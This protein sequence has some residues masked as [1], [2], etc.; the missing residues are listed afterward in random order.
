MAINIL[1][2][3][4]ESIPLG[5]WVEFIDAFGERQPG[6]EHGTS[7]SDFLVFPGAI[8]ERSEML[9]LESREL[10]LFPVDKSSKAEA[11]LRQFLSHL[12]A[13]I[14]GITV[15]G[16][17]ISKAA[18]QLLVALCE[19]V[20]FHDCLFEGSPLDPDV[21]ADGK[22]IEFC[23]CDLF[24]NVLLPARSQSKPCKIER[25]RIIDSYRIE[26]LMCGGPRHEIKDIYVNRGLDNKVWLS[27]IA[28]NICESLSLASVQWEPSY[29][30][31]FHGLTALRGF[32][33]MDIFIN[34]RP[35]DPLILPKCV[36]GIIFGDGVTDELIDTAA[37]LPK[38]LSYFWVNQ[39]E[40]SSPMIDQI[41]Q[42][43]HVREIMLTGDQLGG[44]NP[45][46]WLPHVQTVVVVNADERA[47]NERLAP[48]LG[49][50]QLKFH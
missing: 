12:S 45:E 41:L 26:Q 17:R 30:R 39:S 6:F 21:L 38:E 42:Q 19:D 13:P 7:T 29:N 24:S 31:Y 3:S 44:C 28:G 37:G 25:I 14:N 9:N 1:I 35:A 4:G 43:L 23:R 5:R 48:I 33:L 34:K 32:D 10:R 47:A 18:L 49:S 22:Q 20:A 50:I 15:I 2:E 40:L 27:N 36:R 11:H 16:G 46:S 8:F